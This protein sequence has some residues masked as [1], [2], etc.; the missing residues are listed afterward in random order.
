MATRDYT[1]MALL[2]WASREHVRT[3]GKVSL[4]A[5]VNITWQR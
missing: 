5:Q 4:L 2:A 3:G 1:R